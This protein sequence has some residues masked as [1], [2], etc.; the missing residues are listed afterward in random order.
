VQHLINASETM[1]RQKIH[2]VVAQQ[3]QTVRV[4]YRLAQLLCSLQSRCSSQSPDVYL[5]RHIFLKQ[6]KIFGFFLVL[7]ELK[8]EKGKEGG[9][10]LSVTRSAR[11]GGCVGALRVHP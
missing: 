1:K 3:R 8:K 11:H 6:S 7:V 10:K 2:S 4:S 5:T 9:G